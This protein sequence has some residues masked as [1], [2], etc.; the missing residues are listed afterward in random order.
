MNTQDDVNLKLAKIEDRNRRVDADK[1]WERSW[2]RRI[3][4]AVLT[5]AV[6]CVFLWTINET[7][8]FLKALVPVLGFI[9]S[10]L[11]LRILRK[12]SDF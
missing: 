4:V 9:L 12:V 6:A 11:S 7:N 1:K 8:I 5:Y 2:T 10:T 3:A